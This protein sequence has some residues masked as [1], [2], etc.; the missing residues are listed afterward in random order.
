MDLTARIHKAEV[1]D[2]HGAGGQDVLEEPA[3]EFDDVEMSRTLPSACG[4]TVGDG[5]GAILEAHDAAVGDGD[6]EDIRGEVFKGGV[7]VNTVAPPSRRR[8]FWKTE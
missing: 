7:G 6:F 4:F 8:G 1:S 5:D 2:F 3:D